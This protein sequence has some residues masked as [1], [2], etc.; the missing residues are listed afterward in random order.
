MFGK[1]KKRVRFWRVAKRFVELTREAD[2][3]T[4]IGTD[5]ILSE[6]AGERAEAVAALREAARL[7]TEA[8]EVLQ[9]GR[10]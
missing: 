1:K 3:L 10:A 8:C 5:K 7:N 2:K 4:T 9:Y 6:D